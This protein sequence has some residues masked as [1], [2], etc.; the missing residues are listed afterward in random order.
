MSTQILPKRLKLI[1]QPLIEK[2]RDRYSAVEAI[3]VFGSFPDHLVDRP[4]DLDVALL[5]PIPVAKTVDPKEWWTLREELSL[6]IDCPV[7]LVNMRIVSTV[8]QVQIFVT[9]YRAYCYRATICNEYEGLT[10]SF[11]QKLNDE[12]KEILEAIRATG[13]IY[14]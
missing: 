1:I 7:D 5:L 4:N 13:I 14:G 8:F 3:Y 9:G 2:I 6:L 11:Y 12:R 10:L